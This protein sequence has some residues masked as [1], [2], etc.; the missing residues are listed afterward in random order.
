MEHV[1]LSA[2]VQSTYGF[3]FM[4]PVVRSGEAETDAMVGGVSPLHWHFMGCARVVCVAT[5]V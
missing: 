5:A 3:L 2:I 1:R 4:V